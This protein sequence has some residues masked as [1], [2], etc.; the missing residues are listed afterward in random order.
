[1]DHLQTFFG[2]NFWSSQTTVQFVQHIN[3]SGTE[4]RTHDL[5]IVNLLP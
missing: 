2:I 3:V 1:M 4:I 5:L